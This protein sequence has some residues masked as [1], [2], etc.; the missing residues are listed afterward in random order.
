[1]VIGISKGHLKLRVGQ[2]SSEG[3]EEKR[4]PK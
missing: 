4:L 3:F 2:Q 1:V